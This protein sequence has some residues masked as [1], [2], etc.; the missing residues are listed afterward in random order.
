MIELGPNHYGKS[1]IRLVKV[2]RAVLTLVVVPI[3]PS[4]TRPRPV[5]WVC[6][7]MVRVIAQVSFFGLIGLR[8]A[9]DRSAFYLLVGN[10]L[11]VAAQNGIFSLNMTT[12]ERWAGT[13]PL[14]FVA[15]TQVEQRHDHETGGEQQA[16]DA[17]HDAAD[18]RDRDHGVHRGRCGVCPLGRVDDLAQHGEVDDDIRELQHPD[19]DHEV[20][21]RCDNAGPAAFLGLPHA[22]GHRYPLSE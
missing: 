17:A 1:G 20:R 15:A 18:P 5:S 9:N 7:W 14:H 13:L 8:V 12:T 19:E 6:G 10:S 21:S 3:S 2:V 11:A 4:G 16:Q 22:V